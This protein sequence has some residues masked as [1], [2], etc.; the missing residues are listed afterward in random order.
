MHVNDFFESEG[1]KVLIAD[2][3]SVGNALR[4]RYN[5]TKG[6]STVDV[7]T[8]TP[9]TIAQELVTA[10]EAIHG[11][12]D[13][14][15]FL[16]RDGAAYVFDKVISANRPDFIP[17]ESLTIS[18][19]KQI[20]QTLCDI[21]SFDKTASY[22]SPDDKTISEVKEL[23]GKY[24]ETLEKERLYDNPAIL[25]KGVRILED[26]RDKKDDLPLSFYLPWAKNVTLGDMNLNNRKGIEEKIISLLFDICPHTCRDLEAMPYE[27]VEASKASGKV[28]WSFYESYGQHNEIKYVAQKIIELTKDGE[29]SFDEFGLVY[30]SADYENFIAGVF[31]NAKIPYEFEGC[32]HAIN[33]PFGQ[34]LIA[35]LDFVENGYRFEDIERIILNEA[36][37]FSKLCKDSKTVNP[38]SGLAAT[39]GN[40][41]GWGRERFMNYL[42]DPDLKVADDIEMA[43]EYAGLSKE[44]KKEKDKELKNDRDKRSNL[45]RGFFAD[46]VKELLDV[47]DE[48]NSLAQT[49]KLLITFVGRYT[50]NR[51]HA[52]IID[53]LNEQ[54]QVFER[55]SKERCRTPE[56]KVGYIRDF[57]EKLTVDRK[58]GSVAVSIRR[59]SNLKILETKFNYFI[60]MGAKQFAVKNTESAIM[61]DKEMEKYLTGSNIRRIMSGNRN[62]IRQEVFRDI[63]RSLSEGNITVGYSKYNTIEL[64]ESSPSVLFI[65]IKGNDKTDDT[66]TYDTIDTDIFIEAAD[67]RKWIDTVEQQDIDKGKKKI[68][69]A[70]VITSDSAAVM[71]ASRLQDLLECPLKYY[72]KSIRKLYIQENR[73]LKGDEWLSAVDRGNL[74]HRTFQHYLEAV[75][76]PKGKLSEELDEDLFNRIYDE[77]ATKMEEEVP[78]GSD[79]VKDQEKEECRLTAKAYLTDLHKEWSEDDA[80]GKKWEILGCELDFGGEDD[81]IYED[82][83]SPLS[84][85]VTVGK[86]KDSKTTETVSYKD[87][88]GVKYSVR[89]GKG[90]IDRLDG[91]VDIDETGNERLNLRIIDY[92][93]GDKA[94]LTEKIGMNVQIQHFVYAMA[95]FAHVR[96]LNDKKEGIFKGR[97]IRS[98]R[99]EEI[100][101]DFPLEEKDKRRYSVMSSISALLIKDE[102]DPFGW[103]VEFPVSVRR[104]LRYTEGFR[105]N[106]RIDDI[107]SNVEG[108][109]PQ[110]CPPYCDYLDICRTKCGIDKITILSTNDDEDGE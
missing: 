67:Y 30:T 86:S 103:R 29:H 82:D 39:P 13:L 48:K 12:E 55:V 11:G 44:E 58:T 88:D 21:R 2:H 100:A 78:W 96:M 77:Q 47:F 49:Y 36:M 32:Y 10:Y 105:Q 35:I 46:F 62:I 6:R 31:D 83:G 28:N 18:T 34:M 3:I 72:Y 33:M 57:L 61:S 56:Q 109:L 60:G 63:L 51:S 65:D 89:F 92:K 16:S 76:P 75:M 97:D 73:S 50:Y 91:Y 110:K 9:A 5:I 37:T 90:Q 80:N 45:N 26:I 4:R 74:L 106:K 107:A 54:I 59:F 23:I 14:P 52:G 108:M 40:R 38:N 42:N 43:H 66:I 22:E 84:E 7:T 87:L 102:N 15:V 20:Y 19:V 53:P 79:T 99:I 104:K 69:R 81:L 1:K 25:Q 71:S 101:Y 64:R 68:D 98:V 41:I 95:A 8:M 17:K 93:T 70:P 27:S 94:K 85:T 24:E